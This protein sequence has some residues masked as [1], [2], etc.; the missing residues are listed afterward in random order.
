VATTGAQ[1][2]GIPHPTALVGH[3]LPE[4][5]G[6]NGNAVNRAGLKPAATM[7]GASRLL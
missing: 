7:G 4:G 1:D 3:P 6:G 2:D 5:E